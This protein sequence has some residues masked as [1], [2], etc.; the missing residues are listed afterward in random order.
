L[1]WLYVAKKIQGWP[2]E[3]EFGY[4]NIVFQSVNENKSGYAV[5]NEANPTTDKK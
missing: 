1:E 5:E 2:E 3:V 4:R